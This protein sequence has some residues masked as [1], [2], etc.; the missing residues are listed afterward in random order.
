MDRQE[1]TCPHLPMSRLGNEAMTTRRQ[2]M[3]SPFPSPELPRYRPL[4]SSVD[5]ITVHQDKLSQPMISICPDLQL[6][7]NRHSLQ[8]PFF[9]ATI[10]QSEPILPGLQS[11]QTFESSNIFRNSFADHMQSGRNIVSNTTDQ[12][13]GEELQ[14]DYDALEALS[15]EKTLD[16]EIQD[17]VDMVER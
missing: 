7:R 2:L 6:P 14:G 12:E 4:F 16:Q 15:E 1:A 13:M 11:S 5:Q 3:P 9:G 8:K 17:K 10:P